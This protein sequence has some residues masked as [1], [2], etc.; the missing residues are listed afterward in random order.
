MKYFNPLRKRRFAVY[1]QKKHARYILRLKMLC[2][3]TDK[4]V[5]A[6][7]VKYEVI[8]LPDN[9]DFSKNNMQ[10]LVV[11]EK[12][13]QI[14]L[15]Q[16]K[17]IFL[18]FDKLK[19]ISPAASIVLIAEI[20][21]SWKT[22]NKKIV[23]KNLRT[24]LLRQQFQEMG[25]YDLLEIREIKTGKK[26]RQISAN[27]KYIKFATDIEDNGQ[28]AENIRS[29]IYDYDK[30]SLSEE[31]KKNLY[32]GLLECM[33]NVSQHAYDEK[34]AKYI[35]FPYNDRRWW[36]SGY[37]DTRNKE[38]MIQFYDQGAGIPNTLPSK[39]ME[40]A[41]GFISLSPD[42]YFIKLA[43]EIKQSSTK[44]DHRGKGLPQIIDVIKTCGN[45]ELRIISNKG[46]CTIRHNHN[47][48]ETEYLL[49]ENRLSLAG[50]LVQWKIKSV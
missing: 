30:F 28:I 42:N 7:D 11:F 17:P 50:T 24:C 33:S 34:F 9:L 41:I 31:M 25:F 26:L 47:T 44:E 38:V 22:R 49:N 6:Q 43:T 10:T 46:D 15:L 48:Q 39:L 1:A 21:R 20:Y 19:G 14:S 32:S 12:F 23:G 16:D 2:K 5:V 45:G 35:K 18:D 40:K 36:A 13:R 37:V 3:R 27:K 29:T 8:E 4:K